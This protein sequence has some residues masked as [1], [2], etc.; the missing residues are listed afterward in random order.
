[1]LPFDLYWI[2]VLVRALLYFLDSDKLKSKEQFTEH[3]LD[4]QLKA[5]A[6]LRGNFREHSV[7]MQWVLYFHHQ[8]HTICIS[9]FCLATY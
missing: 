9:L 4:L 1:M 2:Y 6:A 5:L 8:I 3:I 7:L